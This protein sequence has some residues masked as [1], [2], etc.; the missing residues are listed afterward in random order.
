MELPFGGAEVR[1]ARVEQALG[2][3]G[4]K[5]FSLIFGGGDHR[6]LYHSLRDGEAPK[7]LTIGSKD[8]DVLR[9]PWVIELVQMLERRGRGT[10]C[11]P[12]GSG[13]S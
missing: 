6:E 5:L 2:A 10:P 9:L 12:A 4:K 1:A 3:R 7:L 13:R 11:L 8:L